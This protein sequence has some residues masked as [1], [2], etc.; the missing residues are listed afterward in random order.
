MKILL[1]VVLPVGVLA[2]GEVDLI[3]D[4]RRRKP[5][6][7]KSGS[8]LRVIL[9]VDIYVDNALRPVLCEQILVNKIDVGYLS[10]ASRSRSL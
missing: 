8:L 1:P 3:F 4:S 2:L 7:Q 9:R 6:R 10:I 5:F